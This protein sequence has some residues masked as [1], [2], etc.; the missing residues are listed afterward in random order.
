LLLIPNVANQAGHTNLLADSNYLL[1]DQVYSF[2]NLS[3]LRKEKKD[4]GLDIASYA[5]TALEDRRE[6][7]AMETLEKKQRKSEL[8]KR[9]HL[10]AET[11]EFANYRKEN[12]NL[13]YDLLFFRNPYLKSI[14]LNK[15]S[16][17]INN[18]KN[19]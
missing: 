4:P 16:L 19:S 5:S 10:A 2:L 9:V 11:Q 15:Q 17:D 8:N 18:V 14:I 3:Q 13:S 7:K 1:G 12:L 6:R